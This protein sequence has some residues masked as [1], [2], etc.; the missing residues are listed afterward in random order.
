M[1]EA[2]IQPE[3][4]LAGAIPRAYDNVLMS[5]AAWIDAIQNDTGWCYEIADPSGWDKAH[6]SDDW[7]KPISYREFRRKLAA[8]TV[9][10][11]LNKINRVPCAPAVQLPMSE[12][13]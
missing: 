4:P 3:F 12:V 9:R 5:S 1:P 13:L 11:T 7:I 8:S 6:F 10:Y 2:K